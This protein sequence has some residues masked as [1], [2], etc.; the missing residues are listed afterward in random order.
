MGRDV[1]GVK[2]GVWPMFVW[3]KCVCVEGGGVSVSRGEVGGWGLSGY[4]AHVC[5]AKVCVCLWDK[6]VKG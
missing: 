2:V 5:V 4:V 1:G 3:P 6:C